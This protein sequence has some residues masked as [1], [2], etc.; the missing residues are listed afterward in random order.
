V[1][2]LQIFVGTICLL[3]RCCCLAREPTPRT[4]MHKNLVHTDPIMTSRI[5]CP[6]W[7]RLP[8][9]CPRPRAYNG[10]SSGRRHFDEANNL[11]SWTSLFEKQFTS[12]FPSE[13]ASGI[14]PHIFPCLKTSTD[15]VHFLLSLFVLRVQYISSG[16]Y[17][18]AS[19]DNMNW[20]PGPR[21]HE[22]WTLERLGQKR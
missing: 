2:S 9:I 5:T 4:L 22:P 1:G 8:C 15:G 18:N 10:R 19:P 6:T 14:R 3:D 7:H 11:E 20:S 16:R 17:T 13:V 12:S 21:S